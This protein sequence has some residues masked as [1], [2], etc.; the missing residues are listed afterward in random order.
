MCSAF[1][2]ADVVHVQL[3]FFL[4]YRALA[5]AE[6]LRVPVVAG[7]QVQPENMLRGLSLMAPRLASTLGAPALARAL[8]RVMT[9]TFDNR[10]T[11]SSSKRCAAR[12]TRPRCGW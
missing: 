1:D 8:N 12:S 3:P 5:L 9:Q 2:R 10:A 7:H 6:E 4:G 11:I